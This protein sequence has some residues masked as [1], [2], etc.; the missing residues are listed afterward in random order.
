MANISSA[1]GTITVKFDSE[2]CLQSLA[3][4]FTIASDWEYGIFGIENVEDFN[5]DDEFTATSAFAAA[6]RWTFQE[7]ICHL[8]DWVEDSLITVDKKVLEDSNF[9]IKFEYTDYEPGC[10]VH[11]RATD[12]LIHEAG[13]PLTDT[14][15]V[16][17]DLEELGLDWGT[18]LEEGGESEDGLYSELACLDDDGV[19]EF[20]TDEKEGLERYF[21]KS[22][23]A[24]L[25]DE[26][27]GY[28]EMYLRGKANDC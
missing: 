13:T 20:L 8:F 10:E 4:V 17:G 28:K 3:R 1:D 5:R 19:Y 26:F 14:R 12:Y 27:S 24:L 2:S 25:D 7:N 21:N 6:G 18:R 9:E 15:F 16:S 23:K 22:L 11:Y